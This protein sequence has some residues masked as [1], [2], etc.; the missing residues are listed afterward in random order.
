[1]FY[2]KYFSTVAFGGASLFTSGAALPQTQVST[3]PPP[4]PSPTPPPTILWR[5]KVSALRAY[6]V[7]QPDQVALKKRY[8]PSL[9]VKFPDS[10]NSSCLEIRLVNWD[11]N[12]DVPLKMAGVAAWL[13]STGIAGYT[14]D[15]V[16]DAFRY[17]EQGYYVDPHNG[18]NFYN[19]VRLVFGA[20]GNR[21][22]QSSCG[23]RWCKDVDGQT[24]RSE[25]VP[26]GQDP[27]LDP[28]DRGSLCLWLR[29]ETM[30]Q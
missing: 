26:K 1:M 25:K 11:C 22:V 9:Q 2:L 5:N 6:V 3:L 12:Y 30:V 15:P 13:D 28:S 27:Y 14:A 29:N 4:S 24:V 18:W 10:S 8:G 17:Y 19:E 21:G 7:S 23:N 20:C 16:W